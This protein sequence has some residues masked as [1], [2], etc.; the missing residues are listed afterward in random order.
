MGGGS[1]WNVPPG[2][3]GGRPL[4]GKQGGRLPPR[5]KEERKKRDPA[6]SS[7]LIMNFL[8]RLKKI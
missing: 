7:P 4:L 2:K 8:T 5:K 1:G 3:L 6:P